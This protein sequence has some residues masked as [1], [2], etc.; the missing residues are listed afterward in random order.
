MD[1]LGRA[2]SQREREKKKK[3]KCF[4]LFFL[5]VFFFLRYKPNIQTKSQYRE[6]Q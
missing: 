4:I 2:F 6:I 5:Q 1:Y 3:N